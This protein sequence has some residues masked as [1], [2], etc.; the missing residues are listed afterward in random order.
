MEQVNIKILKQWY[1]KP[2]DVEPKFSYSV[3]METM[4]GYVFL[5]PSKKC[6]RTLCVLA[7]QHPEMVVE[8]NSKDNPR[9]IQ[10]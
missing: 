7:E 3:K 5:T 6:Y 2:A 1:K 9:V 8:T 4:G 10:A